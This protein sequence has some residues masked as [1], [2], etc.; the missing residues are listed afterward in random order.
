MVKT[1]GTTAVGSAEIPAAVAEAAAA[2]VVSV[3][4]GERFD[5]IEMGFDAGAGFSV[6]AVDFGGSDF[7][8]DVG[9]EEP[10]AVLL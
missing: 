9:R 8:E 5:S 4:S 3:F 10:P 1:R 2:M 7:V 6:G